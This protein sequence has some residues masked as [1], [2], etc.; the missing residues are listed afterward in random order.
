[1]KI[2]KWESTRNKGRIY[3]VLVHG[4]IGW[5]VVTAVL[6][7]LIMQVVFPVNTFL[8]R[9]LIALILFPL[10]GLGFGLFMWHLNEKKYK[11]LVEDS[12]TK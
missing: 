1:M 6:W 11:Q 7:S 4:V 8:V 3:F 2:E 9:T 12:D 5:G 10:G